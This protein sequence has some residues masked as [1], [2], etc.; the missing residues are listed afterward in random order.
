VN[1]KDEAGLAQALRRFMENDEDVKKHNVGN[2]VVWEMITKEKK[3]RKGAKPA[4]PKPKAPNAALAVAHSQLFYASDIKLM[5]KVLAGKNA[6][7]VAEKDFQDV[8][9][10]LGKLGAGKDCLRSFTRPDEDFQT[11]YELTRTHQ[12]DKSNSLY[13][14]ALLNL[15]GEEVKDIDS[16]KMPDYQNFRRYVGPNGAVAVQQPG[17]WFMV[18]ALLRKK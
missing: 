16:S 18:G 11:V 17:G 9:A 15:F 12:L 13:A 14:R 8:V 1:A 4:P 3:K 7:L 10:H 5:E 2:V 6:P